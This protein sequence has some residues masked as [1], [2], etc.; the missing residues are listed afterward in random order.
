[1]EGGV[2]AAVVEVEVSVEDV[3]HVFGTDAGGGEGRGKELVILV[4]LA[5]FGRELVAE[6][7]LDDNERRGHADDE[8]VEA[9]EDAV[10]V[11]GGSAAAPE[12]LGNDA[13]HGTA[14]E[15]EGAVGAE[16]EFEVAEGVAGTDEGTIA[17]KGGGVRGD[18]HHRIRLHE[19]DAV[20]SVN[21]CAVSF[22]YGQGR[23]VGGLNEGVR[24]SDQA[25]GGVRIRRRRMFSVREHLFDG[26]GDLRSWRVHL[27]DCS[28]A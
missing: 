21:S 26:G 4:D 24:L 22:S 6:A 5:H 23:R 19:P 27:G 20:I 3:G 7:G 17:R 13:E 16:G 25:E 10:L 18:V 8:G 14:V 15:E 28:D 9:E 11:V 2:P 1:M 12:G